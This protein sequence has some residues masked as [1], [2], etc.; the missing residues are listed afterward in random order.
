MYVT[1]DDNFRICGDR[2]CCWVEEKQQS[3]K[4]KVAG[5]FVDRDEPVDKWERV[6]G[7]CGNLL[8]LLTT[9]A[10]CDLFNDDIVAD[11]D[12]VKR[13]IEQ[14]NEFIATIDAKLSTSLRKYLS[15]KA[16]RTGPGAKKEIAKVQKEQDV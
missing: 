7:Y 16:H 5:K 9:F 13:F 11:L 15:G 12:E 8:Q 14:Q 2:Y 4:K 1:I 10:Y 3:K 6:S